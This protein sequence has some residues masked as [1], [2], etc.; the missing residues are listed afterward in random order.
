MIAVVLLVPAEQFDYAARIVAELVHNLLHSNDL[1]KYQQHRRDCSV[2]R[3]S[4]KSI[5]RIKLL[6]LS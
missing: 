2:T 5:Q 6:L 3:L 1:A 4:F